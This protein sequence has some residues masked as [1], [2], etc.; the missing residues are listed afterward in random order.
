MKMHRK[1]DLDPRNVCVCMCMNVVVCVSIG[2]FL[3]PVSLT[4]QLIRNLCCET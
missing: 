4:I 2:F 3:F 1:E